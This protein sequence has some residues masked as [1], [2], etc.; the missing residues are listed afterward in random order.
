MGAMIISVEDRYIS[1]D[2]E[3]L[4]IQKLSKQDSTIYAYYTLYKI[5]NYI[6]LFY[7]EIITLISA[8]FLLN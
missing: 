6:K 8:K 2:Q 1:V 4:F 7:D 3:A 5:I